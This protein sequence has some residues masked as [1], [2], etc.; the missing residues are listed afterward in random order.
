[1]IMSCLFCK[2]ADGK[3]PASTVYEDDTILAFRD[4]NPQAPTHLLVIP[5]RHIA[6]IADTD[7]EDQE[8]LGHMLLTAKQL[9][10]TE[11]LEQ[12]YR[13][14]F[15]VNSAGGQEVYHIHL[16]ILGGRQ[17]TWPPG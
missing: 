6:T 17:M 15:N 16:H 14:V 12:G 4:I 3:I 10:Q 5:K 2:I 9:A 7:A 11:G 1:M 13:L 8:L